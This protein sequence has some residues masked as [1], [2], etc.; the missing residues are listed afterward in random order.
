MDIY[1][2]LI[3]ELQ[4][5]VEFWYKKM[6]LHSRLHKAQDHLEK[7]FIRH[8]TSHLNYPSFSYTVF[9]INETTMVLLATS[10]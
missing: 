6:D 9:E 7:N 1:N 3:P 5:I 4:L 8:Q 2:N 10:K